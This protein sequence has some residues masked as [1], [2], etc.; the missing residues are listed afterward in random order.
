MGEEKREKE[1]ERER[2]KQKGR[3]ESSKREN[4]GGRVVA[5]GVERNGRCVDSKCLTD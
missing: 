4:K 3:E 1:K 2:G 5:V